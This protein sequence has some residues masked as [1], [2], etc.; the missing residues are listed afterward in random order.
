MA[1]GVVAVAKQ[2]GHEAAKKSHHGHKGCPLARCG[3]RLVVLGAIAL[4]GAAVFE[5]LKK[6]KEDRTWNGFIGGLVPY[7]FRIPTPEKVVRNLW[8]P[9][10]PVVSPKTFGVGWDPNIGR[11]F[12]EVVALPEFFSD[13]VDLSDDADDDDVKTTFIEVKSAKA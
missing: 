6:P 11:I 13:D 9:E 12:T 1:D 2:A 3:H 8:N 5:E 4:A 7:D 10:G